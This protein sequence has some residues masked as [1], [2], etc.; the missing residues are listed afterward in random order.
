[1]PLLSQCLH[2]QDLGFLQIIAEAWDLEGFHP[3]DAR[4][5]L[6]LLPPLLLNS[7]RLE[8]VIL[9]LPETARDAFFDLIEN[10]GLMAW[11]LFTRRYG[12][13]RNM[14]AAR[15]DRERPHLFPASPTEALWYRGLI[16]RSF[17][18]NPDGP[19]EFAFIPQDISALAPPSHRRQP[20]ILGRVAIAA[21]RLNLVF[22]SDSLVDHSCTF[23]A[24]Q[25]A[26]QLDLR[27]FGELGEESGECE[28]FISFL[29]ACLSAAGL[30]DAAGTPK[31]EPTRAFLEEVREAAWASLVNAWLTSPVINELHMVPGLVLEGKWQNDSLRAR[32]AILDLL[33]AAPGQSIH[34]PWSSETSIIRGTSGE[35]SFVNLAAFVESVHQQHPDYQRPAGDYDSWFIRSAAGGDFL[36]GF[37]HWE[38]IDGEFLRFMIGGPLHWLGLVDLAF[39]DSAS[40]GSFKQISAFR[41][42]IFAQDLLNGISPAGLAGEEEQWQVR[43]DG[44]VLTPRLSSRSAR[45]QIARFCDSEGIDRGFYRF[46]VTPA[47]LERAR[48]QGLQVSHLLKLLRRQSPLVPPNLVTALERWEESGSVVQIEKAVILRVRNPE[49]MQA[50]RNSRAARFLG[51]P[52]GPTAIIAKPAAIETILKTLLELGYLGNASVDDPHIK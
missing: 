26:G 28:A 33:T 23:L 3:T 22:A 51:D 4:V 27:A 7:E 14:G 24:A 36:R 5:G 21:E 48:S 32:Q 34:L 30:L 6:Q 38:D 10:D 13:L 20:R 50:L 15:R 18:D 19:Q 42:S 37:D 11:A 44:Q 39:V 49:I 31:P 45:Y 2:G 41:F 46:R 17:F 40:S 12:A 47:S 16:G 35:R 25:R 8:R 52:L 9:D 43:S 29:D 1:M